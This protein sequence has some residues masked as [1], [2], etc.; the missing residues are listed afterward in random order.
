MLLKLSGESDNPLLTLN[1]DPTIPKDNNNDEMVV[2]GFGV[3]Q[4]QGI[5]ASQTLQVGTVDHVPNDICAQASFTNT[6]EMYRDKITDDMLCAQGRKGPASVDACQG[7]SGSPLIM[8]GQSVQQDVQIGIVSWG[9]RCAHPDF[10]GVYSRIS[11]HLEW[12]ANQV[13]QVSENPPA[14]FKCS[15]PLLPSS[16][17]AQQ[18][19]RRPVASDQ[20]Y[21]P[22]KLRIIF[23][24]YA[25]EISWTLKDSS[26]FD[27]AAAPFKWYENGRERAERTFFLV[28]RETYFFSIQDSYRDGLCCRSPGS[29]MMVVSGQGYE[30]EIL[31]F[32]EGNFG[33]TANHEFTVPAL[34][35]I[36][37][38]DISN[39]IAASLQQSPGTISLE[40]F[41][42][43]D[44]EPGEIGWTIERLGFNDEIVA[45]APAGYYRNPNQH[46]LDSIDLQ[47]GEM[48]RF[49][50]VDEGRNG[51]HQ[52][53]GK[54]RIICRLH[55]CTLA[56]LI[57]S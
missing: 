27:V 29:Y 11:Y 23:D 35:N 49:T 46:V 33:A 32:G 42:E 25:S 9:Y 55:Y 17:V 3:T 39:Y 30:G 28:E 40:I 6:A 15:S 45:Q 12:I 52:G 8:K 14:P 4:S 41:L 10:P 21:V 13:C 38:G 48:Y 1:R 31:L 44:G 51:L 54:C 18:T 22:V 37:E 56:V 2:M 50:L 57:L 5:Y 20:G 26:G 16:N 53:R 34:D 7:D 43:L 47:E 19:E 36:G 24:D